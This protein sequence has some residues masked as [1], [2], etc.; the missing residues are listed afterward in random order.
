[1]KKEEIKNFLKNAY[2]ANRIGNFYL[3]HGG[4]E[5]ERK[6]IGDFFS[7]LI[8]CESDKKPCENCIFCNQ[9]KKKIHPDVKWII[10]SKRFLSIDDIRRVKE[11]IYL[12]PYSGSKKIYIFMVDYMREEAANSFLKILEEP[13]LHGILLILSSN[14]NYFLPTIISRAQLLKLNF[15]LPVF[16]E[17][18]KNDEREF[19][20]FLSCLKKNNYRDFFRKIDELVKNR[21]REDIEKYLENIIWFLRD[22]YMK[23]VFSSERLLV[24]RREDGKIIKRE[25]LIEK[26]EYAIEIKRRIKFNINL[27]V[28]LESLLFY[29]ID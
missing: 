12:K 28:G 25:Q 8:H 5:D 15:H 17:E 19:L 29:I 18:M 9:I 23:E 24:S 4:T 27:K 2:K 13:P 7:M 6:E 22:I 26:I 20:N 10:P 1:M 11:Q 16:N 21:E 3:I 14:I